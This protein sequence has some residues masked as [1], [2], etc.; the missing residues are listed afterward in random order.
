MSSGNTIKFRPWGVEKLAKRVTVAVNTVRIIDKIKEKGWSA[1]TFCKMIGK[2]VGWITE[3]K[4]DKNLPSPEETVRMCA[5]LGVEPSEILENQA[6]IEKVEALL[7]A[8]RPKKN[9]PATEDDGLNKRF[10][11]IW[12]GLTEENRRRVEDYIE[13]LANSQRNQ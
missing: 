5:I 3:W 1:S 4:R 13:L 2:S 10:L 8:E 12:E 11:A 6:D 9:Q 7:E